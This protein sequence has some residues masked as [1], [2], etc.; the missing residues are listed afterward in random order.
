M[1][2]LIEDA[3]IF[4]VYL[5]K[6]A[7]LVKER[8]LIL[9]VDGH[10]SH[11][12]YKVVEFAKKENIAVLKLPS[13]TTDLLQ[14][15][16]RTCFGPFK[17]K[18]NAALVGWQRKNQRSLSK[19]EFVDLVCEVWRE[20]LSS[21]NIIS[22]FRACGIYPVNRNKY[23]TDR[24]NPT[25][26]QAYLS[27]KERNTSSA[28]DSIVEEQPSKE[29]DN[30]PPVVIDVFQPED[31]V[32]LPDLDVEDV[33][34]IDE[35]MDSVAIEEISS[36]NADIEVLPEFDNLP[37]TAPSSSLR[38]LDTDKLSFE[39]LL[40]RKVGSTAA[41][42]TKRKMIHSNA[43]VI[44]SEEFSNQLKEASQDP[45]PK[46]SRKANETTINTK[47]KTPRARNKEKKFN[48]ISRERK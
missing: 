44:T 1:Q 18:W 25:K 24:L 48:S 23:P 46:R 28:P 14:P 43:A 21:M 7:M 16:D 42:A 6:F 8:P 34:L 37:T 4:F 40:L 33:I 26:L 39:E 5:Q 17:A 13:H 20:G 30:L 32:L 3:E 41:P 27:D 19:S 9:V 31:V 10:V 45:K 15:L 11:L 38:V 29:A 22:G 47:K 12:D 35:V 36:E 2:Y